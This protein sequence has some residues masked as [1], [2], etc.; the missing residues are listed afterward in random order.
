MA[1][2][3]KHSTIGLSEKTIPVLAEIW[4]MDRDD[5]PNI[6]NHSVAVETGMSIYSVNGALSI[7]E[8][9]HWVRLSQKTV[10]EGN[11]SRKVTVVELNKRRYSTISDIVHQEW[12]N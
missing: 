2:Q 3:T 9:F 12:I 11:R 10:K 6:T 1:H 5:N 7:L 8:R 4:T